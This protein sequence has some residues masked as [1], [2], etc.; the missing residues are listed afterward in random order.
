LSLAA[1]QE[2]PDASPAVGGHHDE[3]ATFLFSHPVD[4]LIGI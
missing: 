2:R 4:A 3:I 1:E